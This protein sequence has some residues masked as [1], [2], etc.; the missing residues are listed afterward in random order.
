MDA[1]GAQGQGIVL[2]LIYNSKVWSSQLG[3]F[4]SNNKQNNAQ[5]HFG[6]AI[7]SILLRNPTREYLAQKD[8]H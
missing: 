4:R 1:Q 2:V 7:S 6:L 3:L 5:Y 8:S